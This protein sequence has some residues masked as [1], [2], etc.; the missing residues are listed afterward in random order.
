MNKV[1]I[2]EDEFRFRNFLRTVIN[3]NEFGFEIYAEARNGVEAL[4]YAIEIKPDLVLIDINMPF[5]DGLEVTA[6]LRELYHDLPIIL[7]TGHSDFEYARKGIKLGILDYV[8]KPFNEEELLPSI[9]K[10]RALI[11]KQL[12]EQTFS[13][14]DSLL[15]RERLLNLLISNECKLSEMEIITQLAE[16]GVSIKSVN[17]IVSSI[18]IDF[19][20]KRWSDPKEISLW[21][22][23]VSNIVDDVLKPKEN[24]ISFNGPEG[25]IIVIV[26]VDD[27]QTELK[28]K[29][30]QLQKVCELVERYLKFSI[31]IGIGKSVNE[32]KELRVSYTESIMALTNK[33]LIGSGQTIEHV[34]LESRNANIGFY[35]NEINENLTMALR[36]NDSPEIK[37]NLDQAFRYIQQK[38][39]SFDFTNMVLVNLV[40]LCLSYVTEIGHSIDDV[41]GKGFSPFSDLK[42]MG[43][44]DEIFVWINKLFGQ[45]LDY[46]SAKKSTKS[47]NLL[48]LA[49]SYIN[50]HFS[51]SELS[52]EQIS[53]D[54]YIS[55]SYLR[56]IFKNELDITVTDYITKLRMNK[57]KEL[58]LQGNVKITDISSMV[59]YNYSPYFS[60]SFK[61]FF[62]VSPSEFENNKNRNGN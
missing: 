30:K 6:R 23:A 58:I 22:Y 57:A 40:S 46:S 26:Q 18:E 39:L 5:M 13:L 49:K 44:L 25:R 50:N 34:V 31:T 9:Q 54:L 20:Y 35:P 7:I 56:K 60:T 51:D 3:W 21:K 15:R 47:K 42:K 52:V 59:G 33:M 4:N 24:Y 37:A 36:L 19:L 16:L 38:K 62:G 10:A 28:S 45:V 55:S 41:F 8:L 61:K 48:E 29:V 14:T 11:R 43:S 1:L 12:V 17:F 2:A 32:F 53:Q 27:V